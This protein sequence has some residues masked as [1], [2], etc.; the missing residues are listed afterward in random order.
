MRYDNM[1]CILMEATEMSKQSYTACVK[2][3]EKKTHVDREL[4]CSIEGLCKY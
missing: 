3:I 1:H 2:E 4:N